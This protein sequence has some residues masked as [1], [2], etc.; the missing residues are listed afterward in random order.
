MKKRLD[1]IIDV[2]F[3]MLV[4]MLLFMFISAIPIEM[5]KPA[6]QKLVESEMVY[7]FNSNCY[8]YSKYYYNVFF[9]YSGLSVEWIRHFD[10]DS[11]FTNNST[12]TFVVVGGMMGTCIIDQTKYTCLQIREWE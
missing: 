5:K 2:T 9:N 12:H 4:G 8:D 3:G 10:I 6:L 7:L 11:N 1:R